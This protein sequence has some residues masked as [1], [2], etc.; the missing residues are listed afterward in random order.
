[1]FAEGSKLAKRKICE[2][3]NILCTVLRDFECRAPSVAPPVASIISQHPVAPTPDADDLLRSPEKAYIAF[4]LHLVSTTS[5]NNHRE[6][7]H[8]SNLCSLGRD[9]LPGTVPA[10]PPSARVADAA[11]TSC[12]HPRPARAEPE[13]ARGH[14]LLLHRGRPPR[15]P[16]AAG[17]LPRTI[18]TVP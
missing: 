3:P 14:E 15:L 6:L 16:L 7:P 9:P 17:D 2:K 11:W 10:G 1:M 13:S 4:S 18:A 12:G 8:A 5:A